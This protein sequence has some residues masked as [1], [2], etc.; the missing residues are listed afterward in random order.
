VS[1]TLLKEGAKT[2]RKRRGGAQKKGGEAKED[3]MDGR[4]KSGIEKVGWGLGSLR[5][6]FVIKMV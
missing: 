4:T 2:T 6:K 3:L 5:F 1:Q